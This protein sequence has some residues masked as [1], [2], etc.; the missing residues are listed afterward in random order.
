VQAAGKPG[1]ARLQRVAFVIAGEQSGRSVGQ[2]PVGR[3]GIG[4]VSVD[5]VG[6]QGCGDRPDKA[7]L[8][9]RRQLGPGQHR[10]AEAVQPAAARDQ[11]GHGIGRDQRV[12]VGD[13]RLQALGPVGGGAEQAVLLRP[14]QQEG[15]QLRIAERRAA[16]KRRPG[17]LDMSRGKGRGER[18]MPAKW[19]ASAVRNASS[20]VRTSRASRS[21]AVRRSRSDSRSV[22]GRNRS[23]IAESRRRTAARSSRTASSRPCW[24]GRFADI[25]LF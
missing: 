24:C 25:G 4:A 15:V 8:Q 7:V 1:T 19:A 18:L 2:G 14:P 3:G 6:A 16:L 23:H 11:H 22:S 21:R 13:E 5:H 10:L 20:T 9:L 17:D 12:R